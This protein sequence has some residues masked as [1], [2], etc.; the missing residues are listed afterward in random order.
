MFPQHAPAPAATLGTADDVCLSLP[1]HSAEVFLGGL[2]RSLTAAELQ[3]L[4]VPFGEGAE[5][6][7]QVRSGPRERERAI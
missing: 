5:V 3:E 2:P 7:L 4:V 6:R 1:P